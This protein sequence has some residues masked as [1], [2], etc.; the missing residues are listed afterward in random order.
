MA[1][2]PLGTRYRYTVR[3]KL[4]GLAADYPERDFWHTPSSHGPDA[5]SSRPCGQNGA[6]IIRFSLEGMRAALEELSN[7]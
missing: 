6:D 3:K 1:V 4:E 7:E 5:W 2:I